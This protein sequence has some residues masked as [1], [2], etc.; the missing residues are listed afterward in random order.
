MGHYIDE[1]K[2]DGGGEGGDLKMED[3]YLSQALLIM[4]CCKIRLSYID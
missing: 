3:T 2:R 1:I 4:G